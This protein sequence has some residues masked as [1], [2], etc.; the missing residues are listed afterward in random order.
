[1]ESLNLL[2]DDD[3]SPQMKFVTENY[4]EDVKCD[5]L[6]PQ[7][8]IYKVLMKGKQIN[9]FSDILEEVKGLAGDQ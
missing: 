6:L 1:M 5:Y 8:E 9:S 4:A 2:K 7:L 3:I